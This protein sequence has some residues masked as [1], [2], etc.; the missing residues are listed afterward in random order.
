MFSADKPRD[1]ASTITMNQNHL[2]N[3][4]KLNGGV[5]IKGYFDALLEVPPKSVAEIATETV[6]ILCVTFM[7][8]GQ[9]V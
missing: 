3:F 9:L 6:G 7:E 1:L 5:M 2:W 8:E 4:F